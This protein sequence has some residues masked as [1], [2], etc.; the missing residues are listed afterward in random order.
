MK[1]ANPKK[2]LIITDTYTPQTNGVVTTLLNVVQHI[3]NN[4]DKVF[5]YHSGHAKYKFSLPLYPEIKIAILKAKIIRKILTKIKWDY[6]HIA[7]LE[8]SLGFLFSRQCKK[9]GL[10]FSASCHTKFP[11]YIHSKIKIFPISFGWFLMR[12]LYK[13]AHNILTTTESMKKELIKHKITPPINTWSRGVDRNIFYPNKVKNN[14]KPTLICVARVSSEK[15]LTKFFELNIDADKIMI[16]DGPDLKKYQKKY[17][18]VRFVGLKKGKELASFYQNADCFVF[19]SLT[20]TFGVVI[21][22]AI[23]CGTPVA[24]YPITG[25][26]DIIK[27]NKNGYLDNNLLIATKNALQVDRASTHKSSKIWSWD[28]CYQQFI[29]SLVKVKNVKTT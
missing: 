21:I 16:G 25:P 26:I 24:A 5:V 27:N 28:K 17:P 19:P 11:E 7:T 6:I 23:A 8:G 2:I 13:N 29:Q 15:N 18:N 3:K 12:K 1:K 4:G 10:K 14:T 9:L 20:D 22:E